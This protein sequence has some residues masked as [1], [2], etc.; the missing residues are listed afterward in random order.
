MNLAKENICKLGGECFARIGNY[1]T[2]YCSILTDIP[3][4][5]CPFQKPYR[6]VT[7]DEIYPLK[8]TRRMK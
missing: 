2:G 6:E 7:N 5:K 8:Q 3:E 1:N 4:D